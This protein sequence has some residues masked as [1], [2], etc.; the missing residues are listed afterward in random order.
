MSDQPKP[1]YS[2]DYDP[3][4]DFDRW[5]THATGAAVARQLQPE[6]R[7]LEL[8]CATGLMTAA[9]T[10]ERVTV[11]GVDRSERYLERA[12]SR[13]LLNATFL[14]GDVA[15]FDEGAPYDH[16]VATNLIHELSDVAGFFQSCYRR[17]VAG[18]RLHISL[19]NPYSIHR[20]AALE[21]GLIT[22]LFEI[23]E[24]GRQYAT[25]RLFDSGQLVAMGEAAGFSCVHR[26][27]IMLKPLP[28]SLM[29][30]LPETVLESFVG[31]SRHFPEHCAVNY[32]V[33]EK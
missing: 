22:D 27:G 15:T 16:I 28:N 18:G 32:L 12:R 2:T 23:S 25:I 17:L 33:L 14:Q 26:E 3:D 29:A 5:Y 13:G 31:V 6:E 20:L 19:Q 24:I 9:L 21:R 1:D 4:S 11:V 7:V 10:G 8:G 30:T